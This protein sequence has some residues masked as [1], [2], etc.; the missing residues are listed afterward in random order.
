[1]SLEAVEEGLH[2]FTSSPQGHAL[3]PEEIRE[4][5]RRDDVRAKEGVQPSRGVADPLRP[6]GEL[7]RSPQ[8]WARSAWEDAEEHVSG[9]GVFKRGDDS[10]E[11]LLTTGNGLLTDDRDAVLLGCFLP[12]CE[13][14][15]AVIVLLVD[16]RGLDGGGPTGGLNRPIHRALRFNRIG[17][18]QEVGCA[19]SAIWLENEAGK[20]MVLSRLRCERK[21][22]VV[23][24]PKLLAMKS[25]SS[26]SS[27]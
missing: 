8:E 27:L 19:N 7:C 2:P 3:D 20:A 10:R 1:M 5:R 26:L 4:D 21:G 16:H 6:E 12:A 9:S 23:G 14:I 11:V 18:G 15:F 22:R 17:G 24:V 13:A 25:T